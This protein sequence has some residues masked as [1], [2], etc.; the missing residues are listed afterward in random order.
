MQSAGCA[1]GQ[2]KFC[3]VQDMLI[4]VNLAKRRMWTLSGEVVHSAAC[5]DGQGK[6]CKVKVVLSE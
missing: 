5:A 3:K 6:F 1:D 2:G 4:G